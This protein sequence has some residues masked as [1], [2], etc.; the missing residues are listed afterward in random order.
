MS[1]A[2]DSVCRCLLLDFRAPCVFVF[3]VCL[4]D[5]M[6]ARIIDFGLSIYNGDNNNGDVYV[7]RKQPHSGGTKGYIAPEMES[8]QA[9]MD[10]DKSAEGSARCF[11]AKVDI[12]TLAVTFFEMAVGRIPDVTVDAMFDPLEGRDD[13]ATLELLKCMLKITPEERPTAAE[14]IDRIAVLHP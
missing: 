12:Y 7:E 6:D 8:M 5:A 14:L 2:I 11:S 1:A 13:P 3:A 10:I 4:T 9:A